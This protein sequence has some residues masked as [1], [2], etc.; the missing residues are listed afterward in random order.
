MKYGENK[1][2]PGF[3]AKSYSTSNTPSATTSAQPIDSL[4]GRTGFP[5]KPANYQSNKKPAGMNTQKKPSNKKSA[6][7]LQDQLLNEAIKSGKSLQVILINGF[8]MT[9]KVDGYDQYVIKFVDE[10]T[11]STSMVFKHAISTIKF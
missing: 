4:N 2:N 1:L 8:Q 10:V 6:S 11:N 9:V 7:W 3:K 5:K